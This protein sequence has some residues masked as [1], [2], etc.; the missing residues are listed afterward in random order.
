MRNTCE[1]YKDKK[2]QFGPYSAFDSGACGV[3]GCTS[4][5]RK[6][7]SVVGC[8]HIPYNTGI[9]PAYCEQP[10]CGYPQ[11]YS[12]PGPCTGKRFDEK[13]DQCKSADPGG[14]CEEVTGERDCTYN[15][16]DAGEVYFDE[17]YK[18]VTKYYNWD[19]FCLSQI[20]YNNKTD[21]G[22]GVDW[23]DGI[24]SPSRCRDRYMNV[25]AKFK[26]K[27]PDKPTHLTEPRCD[28]YGTDPQDYFNVTGSGF[29]RT[30]VQR[31]MY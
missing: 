5:Y 4:V 24:Y 26:E 11:W 10:H 30:F 12:L 29:S 28:F 27:Y 18:T 9:F 22:I 20:E 15:V 21:Y 6:Y 17:L 1:L 16:E 14:F 2:T 23:W 3:K 19:Q 25:I 7:G 31:R 8:Q 13:D